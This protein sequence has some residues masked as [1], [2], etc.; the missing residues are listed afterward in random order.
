MSP[1]APG[2]IMWVTEE[3]DFNPFLFITQ[4]LFHRLEIWCPVTLVIFKRTFDDA[5]TAIVSGFFKRCVRR[6]QDKDAVFFMGEQRYQS[7]KRRND[8]GGENNVFLLKPVSVIPFT[9]SP[10]NIIIIPVINAC[11]A[12]NFLSNRERIASSTGAGVE[13]PCLLPRGL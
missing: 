9:P 8:T 12:E 4:S 11:V 2:R 1:D 7:V 3:E 5:T 10:K 6:G 13:K